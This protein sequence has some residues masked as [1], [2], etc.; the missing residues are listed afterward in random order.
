MPT[1]PQMFLF[2][3]GNLPS[4][5]LPVLDMVAECTETT[6]GP[7]KLLSPWQRVDAV[8]K[9]LVPACNGSLFVKV[10]LVGSKENSKENHQWRGAGP[11]EK[12]HPNCLKAKK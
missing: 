10:P 9:R 12:T 5:V 2:E 11:L 7:S 1:S 8:G 6:V 3:E 4:G